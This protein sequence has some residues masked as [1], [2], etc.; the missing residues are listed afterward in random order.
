MEMSRVTKCASITMKI[1]YRQI[2]N[3]TIIHSENWR[4]NENYS[5]LL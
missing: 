1:I 5:H 3:N 4:K 2:H